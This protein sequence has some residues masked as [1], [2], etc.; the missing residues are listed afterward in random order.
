FHAQGELMQNMI[1]RWHLLSEGLTSLQKSIFWERPLIFFQYFDREVAVDTY[2]GFEPSV[3]LTLEGGLYAL[4]GLLLGMG[5]FRLFRAVF[6]SRKKG[7]GA[8]SDYP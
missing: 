6:S 8:A 4:V 3:P 2:R 5:L 7:C 1:Q